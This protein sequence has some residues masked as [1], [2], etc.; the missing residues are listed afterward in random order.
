VYSV[1]KGSAASS[2]CP[3]ILSPYLNTENTES[4]EYSQS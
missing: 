2:V 1:V 3:E 4:T